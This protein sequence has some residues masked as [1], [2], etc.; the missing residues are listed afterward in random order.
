M[1]S[2]LIFASHNA[3]KTKEIAALLD[4]IISIV[5]LNDIGFVEEIVESGSTLEEN[6]FIKANAIHQVSSLN[7]FADDTGLLVEAL[8]GAPGVYSARYAG[9]LKDAQ[10]NNQLLPNN[11]SSH[12]N[13]K[14]KFVTIIHLIWENEHHLF[15]GKLEGTIGF[16]PQ[17]KEG[18]GYDPIFYPIGSDRS[19]AQ[20]TLKEKNRISHRGKAFMEMLNFLKQ[21]IKK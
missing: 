6:A 11:L 20:M 4:G 10:L 18:F 16:E 13:R 3:N 19:L 2:K 1:N 21:R 9:P 17:G 14:A 7:C 8:N 5:S 12:S 15:E